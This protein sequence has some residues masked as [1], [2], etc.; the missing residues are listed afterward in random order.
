MQKHVVLVTLLLLL[1]NYGSFY[2][3][4]NF[5]LLK[6]ENRGCIIVNFPYGCST[7][8][9]ALQELKNGYTTTISKVWLLDFSVK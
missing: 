7:V 4:G 6:F 3:T 1:L 8:R 2:F 5:R 9:M